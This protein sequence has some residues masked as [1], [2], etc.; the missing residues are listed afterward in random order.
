MRLLALSTHDL[1]TE[2]ASIWSKKFK[3]SVRRIY[4]TGFIAIYL[5]YDYE[6]RNEAIQKFACKND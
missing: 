4:L 3:A 2:S 1:Y 5:T 6:M